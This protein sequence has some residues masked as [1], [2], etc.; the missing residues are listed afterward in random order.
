MGPLSGEKLFMRPL[1]LVILCGLLSGMQGHPHRITCT[2]CHINTV[3]SPDGEPIVT[4]N[5]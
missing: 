1:V 5:T 2:K 3:A 4:R